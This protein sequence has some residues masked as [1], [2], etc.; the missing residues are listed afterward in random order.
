MINPETALVMTP[1]ETHAMYLKEI[2][3]EVQ[4]PPYMAS[5]GLALSSGFLDRANKAS[6][7]FP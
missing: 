6:L 3:S 2:P 5:A 7:F 1:T 4:V